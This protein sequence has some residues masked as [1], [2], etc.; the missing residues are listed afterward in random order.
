MDAILENNNAFQN[1]LARIAA[2]DTA[3]YDLLF[4][5]Y[6]ASMVLYTDNILKNKSESEDLVSD[7]FCT[8]YNKRAK[9]AEVK[10]EKSYMFTLLHNR[11][12]DVLRR[13]KRF[14]QEE[15]RDFVSE[16]SVEEVI[17]EVELYARLNEAIDH[18]PRKCADVLRLK[19]EGLDDCEIAEKLGIQYETVRS[20][21]KRGVGILRGKFD[22][23]LLLYIFFIKLIFFLT[24]SEGLY[25][26]IS[27]DRTNGY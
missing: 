1:L 4:R 25:V 24:K 17:F 14:Q 6:Y 26:F 5:K 13:K 18:L 15:L 11:V 27:K 23:T 22:K 20:H 21:V 16:D 8:L 3:A 12:I 2:G 9:L 19:M 10:F 7:L